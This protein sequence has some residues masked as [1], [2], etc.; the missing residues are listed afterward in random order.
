MKKILYFGLIFG[1]TVILSVIDLG[2]FLIFLLT[3]M[4]NWLRC[5]SWGG[6]G[7]EDYLFGRKIRSRS[8]VLF[9]LTFFCRSMLITSGFGDHTL[10]ELHSKKGLQYFGTS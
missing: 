2:D 9:W 5:A 10:K 8:V 1:W 4:Y 6:G 3:K 7:V